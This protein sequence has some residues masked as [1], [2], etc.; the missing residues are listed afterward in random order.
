MMKFPNLFV[1]LCLYDEML[2]HANNLYGLVKIDQ[3]WKHLVWRFVVTIHGHWCIISSLNFLKQ[4]YYS[5][6]YAC[7]FCR[8]MYLAS[9][10]DLVT[11]FGLLFSWNEAIVKGYTL[12]D[13]FP[14]NKTN[15][16]KIEITIWNKWHPFWNKQLLWDRWCFLR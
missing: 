12:V 16:V 3:I 5:N 14:S 6:D 10:E 1:L 15:M 2:C 7:W 13:F 4:P 9:M 11:R 8:A